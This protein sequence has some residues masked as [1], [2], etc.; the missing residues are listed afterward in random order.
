ME[1]PYYKNYVTEDKVKKDFMRLKNMKSTITRPIK[2]FCRLQMT[3][4]TNDITKITDYFSEECR[5]K[6]SF[7][8]LPPP[9]KKFQELR[10][11]PIFDS[12]NYSEIEDYLYKNARGCN[13]FDVKVAFQIIKYLNPRHI[14]DF[15]AGW[16]DR[17]VASMAHGCK[18]DG[19][20]PSRCL[21]PKYKKIIRT[22]LPA[23]K[24]SLYR[25]YM[26]GF[27]DFEPKR[28]KYDMVFT[29]PPFFDLEIY[30]DSQYQSTSKFSSFHSWKE[31]FL[32][33]SLEKS[34]DCLEMEGIIALYITDYTSKNGKK[35]EYVGDA[36]KKLS[37]LGM[38][39]QGNI[40]FSNVNSKNK[41][42]VIY[43]WQKL[44]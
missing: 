4:E 2:K 24:R 17:L 27:E 43:V 26:K 40:C 11:N 33:K 22:L 41:T 32:Y 23:S 30:E 1:Y 20:D 35:I 9:I 25:M 19:V 31:N 5:V 10:E 12:K 38:T 42:R 7:R 8:D 28:G 16:G 36:K 37:E 15:S 34:V 21:H 29:S 3:N 14:L 6:C 18:Y 39:Y 44:H 13:N